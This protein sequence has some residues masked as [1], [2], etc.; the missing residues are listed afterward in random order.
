MRCIPQEREQDVI[1][2]DPLDVERPFG[3]NLFECTEVCNPAVVDRMSDVFY[4]ALERVFPESFRVA[5]RMSDLLRNLAIVFIENQGYTL[6]ETW[7]F[8]TDREYRKPLLSRVTNPQAR[9]FWEDFNR[10]SPR[11]QDEIAASSLNKLDRFLTNTLLRNIFGQTQSS[12]NF[13]QIMDEG[14]VLLIKLPVGLLGEENAEFLGSIIVGQILDAAFSRSDETTRS[15][16]PFRLI[17]DEYQRFVS[18]AFP[19]LQVEARKFGI[20]C[21]VAH[22]FRGQLDRLNQGSTLNVANKIVFRVTPDDALAL[23]REFDCTPPPPLVIGE[24]PIMTYAP[25]PV[26]HL[27]RAGHSDPRVITLLRHLDSFLF[28]LER[29]YQDQYRKFSSLTLP[30]QARMK[31]IE[32]EIES[33]L[34]YLMTSD[35]FNPDERSHRKSECLQRIFGKFGS[36]SELEAAGFDR[37]DLRIIL[38]PLGLFLAEDPCMVPSGQSEPVYDKPRLYSD[39]EAERV[40]ELTLL[41]NYQARCKLVRGQDL[42]EYTIRTLPAVDYLP[43]RGRAIAERIRERSR[44]VYGRPRAEVEKAI[45]ERAARA[46]DR[47]EPVYYEEE[48]QASQA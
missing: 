9:D 19:V 12:L 31:A 2:W 28:S 4:K 45:R 46:E 7:R 6:A 37:S 32:E 18:S 26:E 13:R 36:Y 15:Y 42:F 38:T 22:Q 47:K 5:P 41:P 23:A 17:A 21:L 29:F 16:R 48:N 14:Q 39:V 44:Q 34:Y 20:D 43:R 33:C 3:L 10:K 30:P 40:N 11:I 35:M 1:L 27:R 24:K 8:L 25:R